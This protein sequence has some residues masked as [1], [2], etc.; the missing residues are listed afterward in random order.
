MWHRRKKSALISKPL[1]GYL[2]GSRVAILGTL[3]SDDTVHLVPIVFSNNSNYIYSAID[4]KPKKT[5]FLKRLSNIRRDSIATLLVSD[6]KENWENLSFVM[7]YAKAEILQTRVEERKVAL[8]MLKRKYPQ[9]K[10]SK[11]L[12]TSSTVIRFTPRKIVQW[13]AKTAQK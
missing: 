7:I 13:S 2:S 3:N 11:L 10:D 9:Y 5:R 12:P 8:K 1:L 6:Y 4:G